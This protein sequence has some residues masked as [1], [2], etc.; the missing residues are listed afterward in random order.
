MVG[1]GFIDSD[2]L[3]FYANLSPCKLQELQKYCVLH[4]SGRRCDLVSDPPAQGQAI[5][6]ITTCLESQ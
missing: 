3:S 4:S 5:L 2:F 1:D 6:W